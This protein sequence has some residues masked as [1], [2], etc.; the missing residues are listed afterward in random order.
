MSLFDLGHENSDKP[1]HSWL[2][3]AAIVAGLLAFGAF[4]LFADTPGAIG[5][6]L[7]SLA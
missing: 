6:F 7:N 4:A 5:T 2:V 1:R 3:E